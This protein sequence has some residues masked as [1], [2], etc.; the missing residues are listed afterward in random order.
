MK[1]KKNLVSKFL[2]VLLTVA[3]VTSVAL[4]ATANDVFV[5]N[6]DNLTESY[7]YL[8]KFN[9]A[10][11]DKAFEMAEHANLMIKLADQVI[12]NI[13]SGIAKK[14][15]EIK[16]F[17]KTNKGA[18][19]FKLSLKF[20]FLRKNAKK[21]K[22]KMKGLKKKMLK[23]IK[24]DV[25]WLGSSNANY[26]YATKT[27]DK[28]KMKFVVLDKVAPGDK[29]VAK[30]KK[31]QLKKAEK[32]FKKLMSK[33]AQNRMPKNKYKGGDENSVVAAIKKAYLANYKGSKIK[34]VVIISQKWVT[35]K[36][37]WYDNQK[38]M[39]GT[40]KSIQAHVA[41]QKGKVCKV[42]SATFKKPAAGGVLKLASVGGNYPI[43]TKNVNK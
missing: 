20:N 21:A 30:A 8:K 10:R 11:G 16:K 41:V 25:D 6:R 1:K 19:K 42:F 35:K 27:M 17:E 24:S 38:I 32:N 36:E 2:L 26:K 23:S 3:S 29:D 12:K 5:E 22:E 4:S 28:L 13:E 39:V 9:S 43:L 31:V 34:R 7:D 40:F 18:K 15:K 37:A 14:L 33:M